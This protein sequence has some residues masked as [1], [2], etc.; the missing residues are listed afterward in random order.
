MNRAALAIAVAV[1]AALPLA[2][3]D[4]YVNLASQI[5]IAAV[6]ALSLNLLVG[7]GGL[8]SLGHAAYM[9]VAAYLSGWLYLKLGLGHLLAAPLALA[10]TTL[11]AAVFGLVAL[12]ASGISFLMITLALGQVLWG[13]AFRWV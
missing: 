4:Y 6:F 13:L 11:I 2:A 5:L 8:T 7:Y 12:R 9:G 3:G 10:G 1:L